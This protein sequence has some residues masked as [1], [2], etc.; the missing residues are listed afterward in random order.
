MEKIHAVCPSCQTVNAVLTER[1]RQNPVCAKCATSLLPVNPVE[2]TDQTFERF[3]TRSTLPVLVD[4]WAPWCGPC[5]MMAPAFSQAAAALQGQ[6]ILAKMD[7]EAQRTVPARFN[8]QSV[9]S[10][11]LFRQGRETARTAGAMPAAQI[12]AWVKGQL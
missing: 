11:V 8:I 10:L 12:Q 5:K 2:L 1:I 7:T 6:V 9:P 4:F 3:I